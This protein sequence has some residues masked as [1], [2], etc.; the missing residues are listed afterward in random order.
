MPGAA[1]SLRH[2]RAR[3]EIDGKLDLGEAQHVGP[4]AGLLA[5]P[6][7][8]SELEVRCGGDPDAMRQVGEPRRE[9]AEQAPV[10]QPDVAR[11]AEDAVDRAGEAPAWRVLARGE[12]M[13]AHGT[14]AAGASLAPEGGRIWPRTRRASA[15][16]ATQPKIPPCALIISSATRW[17][18]G[19]YEPTQSD[20]TRHS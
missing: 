17:N 3:L 2:G 12:R 5:D 16:S 18:S 14:Q 7:A 10:V 15:E 20:S 4:A 1:S 6:Q 13:Q 8:I 11:V 9:Q 19:K